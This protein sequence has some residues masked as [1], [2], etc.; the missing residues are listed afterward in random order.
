MLHSVDKL[1]G[2]TI[3]AADGAIG[4][5]RSF[6]FDSQD[7]TIRY[8]VVDTGKWLP[9]RKVLIPP[10]ALGTLDRRN[11][12]LHVHL[13]KEQVRNSPDLDTDKPVS[14]EWETELYRHYGWTPYW[15]TGYGMGG[16]PPAG[17]PQTPANR[18]TAVLEAE[19]PETTLRST[20]EVKGYR[21]RTTDDGIG[22]VEDFIIDD[23]NW[24]IRYLV[25]D[26]GHW[27]P[28]RK[29][30]I[31]PAWVTDIRWEERNVWVDVPRQTI[32]DSPP[33]DPSAP[34]TRQYEAR[35]YDY[36]HWPKYWE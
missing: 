27:L 29:V 5:V 2:F 36:Y 12:I 20:R 3:E 6:F 19:R 22:A 15:G 9:G 16:I 8:L 17:Y 18:Q 7:W 28:G 34:I 33:Y 24:V 14:R 30:L 11:R 31:P 1:K 10:S 26:T 4:E 23:E 13:T 21:I 32:K 25:V 35:M